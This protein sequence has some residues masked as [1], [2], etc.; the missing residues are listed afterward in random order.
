ML[1]DRA[2]VTTNTTGTGTLALGSADSGFQDFS[3][4]SGQTY[5]AITNKD[6]WE[7]GV[8]TVSS[9][10]LTRDQVYDSSSGLNRLNLTGKST[11]FITY[12]ASRAVYVSPSSNPSTGDL[13]FRGVN[14]WDS[15]PL[16]S[17]DITNALGVSPLY[18]ASG[19]VKLVSNNFS[20]GGTGYLNSLYSDEL[21]SGAR[22]IASSGIQLNSGIPSSTS[23]SLYSSGTSLFWNGSRIVP[24]YSL[25]T[26]SAGITYL[27]ESDNIILLSGVRL[28]LFFS[29]T[30]SGSFGKIFHIKSLKDNALISPPIF[31]NPLPPYDSIS[32]IIDGS[33][34]DIYTKK[35]E[36]YSMTPTNSGWMILSKYS[37]HVDGNL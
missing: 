16:S 21:I 26:T 10:V 29:F 11:V 19:G 27:S 15:R 9:G 30:A 18:T 13:L 12:P 1:K 22:F 3:S 6:S 31:V 5:Y 20:L 8:G 4:I 32:D 23:N 2:K 28:A 33:S 35:N 37:N 7:V 24:N 36:C 25:K 34:A 17:G 14:S